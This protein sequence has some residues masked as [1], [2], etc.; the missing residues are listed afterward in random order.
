MTSIFSSFDTMH[1]AVDFIQQ[2]GQA[3]FCSTSFAAIPIALFESKMQV[4]DFCHVVPLCVI[5]L[6]NLELTNVLSSV[7]CLGILKMW[8]VKHSA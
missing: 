4:A 3:L 8:T 2:P 5:K 1:A 7:V 6:M